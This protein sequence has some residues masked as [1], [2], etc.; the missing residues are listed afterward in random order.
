MAAYVCYT[1]RS[2]CCR[3]LFQHF[4]RTN[5]TSQIP[6]QPFSSLAS[7]LQCSRQS[8]RFHHLLRGRATVKNAADTRLVLLRAFRPRRSTDRFE[9]IRPSFTPSPASGSKGLLGPFAFT[10]FVCSSS[11]LGCMIWQ[12]ESMRKRAEQV[13][14]GLSK[15]FNKIFESSEPPKLGFREHVNAVW[16]KLSDG[17]KMVASIIGLNFLV[18]FCWKAPALQ[19]FLMR[20][21][22]S[23][24][25]NPTVSLLLSAFS[26]YNLWH[27]AANMYV[28]WS[29]TQVSINLFGKEQWLAVYLSAASISAFASHVNKVLRHGSLA[30]PSLG[31]SGAIMCLLGAVC[32][33]HPDARLSIAFVGE[34]FPHSFS[35]SSALKAILLLDTVG[36]V[37]GWRVFDHAAHLGGV[38]FGMWYV[39]Y[40]HKVIWNKREKVMRMW[41]EIRG[42]PQK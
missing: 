21:F 29:F 16:R 27:I 7:D 22:A 32:V 31:A 8:Y 18:F 36:L 5:K 19:P 3:Q 41:H 11:F 40:G 2:C 33:T 38:L 6:W 15:D 14:R 1:Y 39:T 20:Y 26:H 9:V 4:S 37:M 24:P 28:L 34:I 30:A 35:A 13:M 23:M 17:Q 12:Y 25:G 42:K 10:V